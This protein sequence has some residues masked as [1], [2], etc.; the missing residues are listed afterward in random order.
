[1]PQITQGNRLYLYQLLSRELGVGKQTKIELA[2]EVLAA[3]DV[4]PTDLDCANARELMEALGDIVRVTIFKR[5]RVYVTVLPNPEFDGYLQAPEEERAQQ[6]QQQRKAQGRKSWKQKRAPKI[7]RPAKPKPKNRPLEV[8]ETTPVE[9]VVDVDAKEPAS[10]P[11]AETKTP[12]HAEVPTAPA[13]PQTREAPTATTGTTAAEPVT[14]APTDDA[15][16][17]TP[18]A[19]P[20][21]AE[22]A[23]ARR[24]DAPERTGHPVTAP[25]PASEAMPAP[26]SA[27][28]AADKNDA[29]AA[30]ARGA[31]PREGEA[32]AT[33]APEASA[34]PL[35][36]T[37]SGDVPGTA[38]P[39]EPEAP[40]AGPAPG[41]DVAEGPEACDKQ[42]QATQV[43][44]ARPPVAD[45][46]LSATERPVEA[47]LVEEEASATTNDEE[48]EPLFVAGVHT[49]IR[50]VS[51]PAEES[52]STPAR[53]RI[54]PD[55]FAHE[56]RME[57]EPLAA[58]YSILPFDVDPL[59]L[60][61]EDWHFSESI[62]SYTYEDARLRFPLR[63]LRSDDEPVEVTLRR[64]APGTSGK[65]WLL[66]DV[67]VGDE[68]GLWGLP[69]ADEG[70]WS[71]MSDAW[72]RPHTLVSPR[73]ELARF[74]HLG[75]PRELLKS[76]AD[77]AEDEW[78]GHDYTFLSDY[79]AITFW[80]ARQ[81]GKIA[82]SLDGRH[83]ALDTGLVSADG[84][85]VLM[86]FEERSGKVSWAFDHFGPDEQGLAP[87]PPTYVS[88]LSHITLVAGA[89]VRLS[90]EVVRSHGDT[91]TPRVEH[92]VR[93]ATRNHRV[94]T[95]A[96]D[97]QT[98]EMRLLVPIRDEEGEV[99]ALV[100]APDTITGYI[101]LS[102][103][104]R[105][106]AYACARAVSAEQPS[107]LR[108]E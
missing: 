72:R 10:A 99:F 97:P 101:A 100:L 48:P 106:A 37:A 2:E 52:E 82:V 34:A 107:W 85:P 104:T 35:A 46:A 49:N 28:A 77:A 53:A 47:P 93:Y 51:M 18:V 57:N 70:A 87:E 41:A 24:A 32:K 58:L 7:P 84:C 11:Q 14:A 43:Q 71:H 45:A 22:G 40:E 12:A 50:L 95:P 86:H 91:I 102:V 108:P 59:A 31:D 65:R 9:A 69:V 21:V 92:A 76:L 23:T 4:L 78:W 15:S 30:G 3:D 90:R 39:A 75:R 79:L 98:D 88:E 27:P 61:D 8:E 29:T 13:A 19:L 56:V 25:V 62:E 60:L 74:A 55:S 44:D 103:M 1:M 5:G 67:A 63:Y 94:A 36:E 68:V 20:N 73:R 83:A 96:F 89:G 26:E 80:R 64:V 17:A 81:Q 66:E 105:E 16:T 38:E 6:Q 33:P 42:A 54:F